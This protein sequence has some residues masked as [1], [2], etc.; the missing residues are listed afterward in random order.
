MKNA[1]ISNFFV[2]LAILLAIP[3]FP[4]SGAEQQP[5]TLRSVCLLQS[6]R[7]R[8]SGFFTQWNDKDVLVT[9]NHVLLEMPDVKIMDINGNVYRYDLIYTSPERDLAVV[10][11]D[12]NNH[13]DM[14]NLL[15][16]PHPDT[17]PNGTAVT[18]YGDS[19]GDGVI[20]PA[21]GKYLG[22]GPEFIEVSA[23]IVSGNS[24]GPILDKKTN[25]IIGVATLCRIIQKTA[26]TAYG[27]R[28]E[29]T[30]YRPAVRRFATRIDNISLDSF[31]KITAEELRKDQQYYQKLDEM[32]SRVIGCLDTTRDTNLSIIQLKNLLRSWQWQ[33][34]E[35]WHSA[36][37]QKE[38]SK[39]IEVLKKL[40]ELL[41][42]GTSIAQDPPDSKLVQA[43]QKALPNIKFGLR[44][45]LSCQCPNCNGSGWLRQEENS[46]HPRKLPTVNYA[47][48]DEC[49]NT[50]K[51]SVRDAEVFATVPPSFTRE[52]ATL[53]TPEKK[54]F[55]GFKAGAPI[56]SRAAIH[57]GFYK[58]ARFVRQ[59]IFLIYRCA[60]NHRLPLAAETRLWMIGNI[61]MRVDIIL[62]LRDPQQKQNILDQLEQEMPDLQQAEL[63]VSAL[64]RFNPVNKP[65]QGNRHQARQYYERMKSANSQDPFGLFYFPAPS[66]HFRHA[67]ADSYNDRLPDGVEFLRI[68]FRHKRFDE[69]RRLISIRTRNTP[70]GKKQHPGKPSGNMFF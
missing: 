23:P 50:G 49:L 22:I 28:F 27:S 24:G 8:G 62:P 55:C 1:H 43:W 9:N 61:L 11:I 20:V 41:G 38:A 14:P 25:R 51:R 6:P 15:R 17:L 46:G 36:Y 42:I 45:A 40:Q 65:Q 18:A 35:K 64:T 10:P 67:D 70:S 59:G 54:D 16:H 21:E 34:P 26:R 69:C 68:S 29:A 57:G 53:L 44:K 58:Q 56:A 32:Y 30:L 3:F 12:R 37:L 66:I 5:N 47:K 60:G 2:I 52:L 63:N 33:A 7:G 39:K 13:L 48:C 4:A 31:E 19:L